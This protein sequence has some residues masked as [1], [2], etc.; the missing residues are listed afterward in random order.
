MKIMANCKATMDQ[1]ERA[2]IDERHQLLSQE[3]NRYVRLLRE[4]ENP[5]QIIVFG[6]LATDNVHSWSDIDLIIVIRTQLSFWERLRA[7]RQLLQPKVATD[8]L[9]YTPEE[10]EEL[11][12]ERPFFQQ[13]ILEI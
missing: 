12:R 2:Y 4:H 11:S 6:S 3:L 8:I 10:F 7:M 13:E 5:E 1:R 9:V